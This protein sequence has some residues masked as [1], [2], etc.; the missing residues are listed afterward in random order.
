[1][2]AVLDDVCLSVQNYAL[3]TQGLTGNPSE[4]PS[5]LSV[6]AASE[7]AFTLTVTATGLAGLTPFGVA[8]FTTLAVSSREIDVIWLSAQGLPNDAIAD[9]LGITLTTVNSHWR[10]IGAPRGLT[11]KEAR[12]WAQEE[13][14]RVRGE[15]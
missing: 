11:R 5:S 12:L 4:F 8:H 3:S 10:N 13:V 2:I 6:P 15:A 7:R 1:M 9:A 14:W